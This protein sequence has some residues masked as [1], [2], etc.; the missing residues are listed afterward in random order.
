MF[1]EVNYW[2]KN[3][4]E[5][6]LT[7]QE[8]ITIAPFT[9]PL[10]ETSAT[11]SLISGKL[12]P[13]IYLDGIQLRGTPREVARDTEFT[14]V[15][16]A[17]LNNRINDRTFKIAVQGPDNP[18]WVTPEDLLAAGNNNTYFILDSAPVDFQLEVLDSDVEAGQQIEYFIGSQGGELPP[19]IR[20]TTD[21]RLVGIVDP[22]RAIELASSTGRYDET[23][24]G[25]DKDLQTGYDWSVPD[26]NGFDSFFYDT[27]IY[28]LST[29]T[30]SPKKLNRFYQFRV[31]ASDG[32]TTTTRT[33]RLYVV[34]DD[35]LRADN[36]IMQVGTGIF[37]ADITHIRVPIWLTPSNFGFRRAN[38][39]VTLVLDVIDPNTLSGVLSY[40]LK[41]TNGDGSPSI[42][43]PGLSLDV[44]TGEIAGRVP[45]QPAVTKEYKFTVAAQ[46]IGYDADR[47]QLLKYAYEGTAASLSQLK[48]NKFDATYVSKV[49]GR[50]FT[51]L[52]RTYQVLNVQTSLST[53]YDV[54]NLATPLIDAIP[55]ATSIDLGT[56]TLVEEEIATSDKTFT[57]N[58]LGEVDSTIAWI[59][60]A[61]LGEFSANYISTLSVRAT[62][63]IPSGTLFY[64]VKSGQLPPGLVLS[65]EGEIIGK[66]RS[67]GNTDSPG[68]TVFDSQTTKF[69]QNETRLD[70]TYKFTVTAQ[71]KFGFS[72]IDRE[73]SITL[74]DP[75]DKQ[76]SN[77]YM[78]PLMTS[79]K[80]RMFADLINDSNIFPPSYLYRPNDPNFGLQTTIKMLL[81][82]GIETKAIN[83]YVAAISQN[84]KRKQYVFGEIKTAIA[85]TPGTR[86][87]VYEVVYLE[88]LDPAQSKTQKKTK[89]QI[90]IANMEKVLVNST[91]YT[92]DDEFYD[93]EFYKLPVGTREEGLKEI[94]FADDLK[95]TA[96]E[97]AFLKKINVTTNEIPQNISNQLLVENRD[98]LTYDV[99]FTPGILKSRKLRPDPENTIT[100]DLSAITVDGD[101][102]RTRYN[103]NL[104]HL[105]DNIRSV[106]ETEKNFMPLWMR[107]SQPNQIAELGLVNAV[108]L[109]YCKPGTS[110]IIANTLKLRNIDFSV[111]DLDID[112]MTID[113]TTGVSQ[114]QYILFANYEY[115][116]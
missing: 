92:S 49:P 31:T 26:N 51:Y 89:K 6:L 14:F 94:K 29:P 28:D 72:A 22:I 67:F 23:G 69:D 80:R 4:G 32:D 100:V 42:L 36:T 60:P 113:A 104:T 44:T 79:E 62:T 7:L 40:Y 82:P 15:L 39:Y 99:P 11:V 59:T 74:S 76:Y 41:A 85:L 5:T 75:D 81:Y 98:G 38:N 63:T 53:Q 35:F 96:R 103:S 3:S 109:C 90:K 106:G 20:L 66:V 52:G 97:S 87:T 68:L 101:Y 21:G 55:K 107:S 50:E 27:T 19:G 10:S 58:L 108:P 93:S 43:P 116:V 77:I 61:N 48:V 54:L 34:G 70:R 110:A 37:T 83:N 102:D 112:R 47:V 78:N 17:S 73:F 88:V 45:Y 65:L 91:K 86:D 57:I 30:K 105:R 114:D 8:Q 16:R 24:V 64:T 71:D 2:T 95:I 25:Y 18:V 111:Y 12:P 56:I 115:N 1:E 46:R 33:F 84:I 13:G 9:L